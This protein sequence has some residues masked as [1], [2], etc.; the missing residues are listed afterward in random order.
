LR[1]VAT[2]SFVAFGVYRIVAG[3]GILVLLAMGWLA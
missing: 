3:G 2:N 1:Y